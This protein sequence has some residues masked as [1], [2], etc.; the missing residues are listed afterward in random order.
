MQRRNA[1]ES[2]HLPNTEIA[3]ADGADLALLEQG[4]H[5]LRGFLDRHQRIGPVH[6][7]D[8]DVLGSQP[9]QRILNLLQDSRAARIA[10]YSSTLPLKPHLGRDVHARAK[11]ALGDRLA[12]DFFRTAEAI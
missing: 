10:E 3:D 9:P 1:T 5:G 2:L 7:I 4:V 12:D 6:L 11:V 8:V